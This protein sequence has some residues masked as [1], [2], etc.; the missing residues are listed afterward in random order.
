MLKRLVWAAG[1][2]GVIAAQ[3]SAA[4]TNP[5]PGVETVA[6]GVQVVDGAKVPSLSLDAAALEATIKEKKSLR[7][8]RKQLGGDGVTSIGPENT[9]VHMYKVHDTVTSQDLVVILFVKGDA[10]VDHLV[11]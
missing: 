1:F 7:A 2:A 4:Q 6:P 10:I 11:T 9:T 8:V 3:S 5:T